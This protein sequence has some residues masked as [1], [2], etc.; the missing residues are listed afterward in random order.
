M[1]QQPVVAKAPPFSAGVRFRSIPNESAGGWPDEVVCL[2]S[3]ITTCLASQE[4]VKFHP[5]EEIGVHRPTL[6]EA[7]GISGRRRYHSVS[8]GGV[9]RM[10]AMARMDF[11][12]GEPR[13]SGVAADP[14]NLRDL[15]PA[16]P[17]PMT[18]W[19]QAISATTVRLVP[20]THCR[21]NTGA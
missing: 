20:S 11:P 5:A 4:K 17:V 13:R 7:T 12:A 6:A 21:A 19:H 16:R 2:S 14:L 10:S 9:E 18:F 3:R 8:D 1:P 15:R